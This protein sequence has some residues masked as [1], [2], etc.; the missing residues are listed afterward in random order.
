LDV[1]PSRL[2]QHP[3]FLNGQATPLAK[4]K[5]AK[6]AALQPIVEERVIDPKRSCD[7]A[8]RWL[9]LALPITDPQL[10]SQ[11]DSR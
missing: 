10:E 8:W 9:E 5:K 11:F 1:I 3:P 2:L 7:E 6:H 4:G